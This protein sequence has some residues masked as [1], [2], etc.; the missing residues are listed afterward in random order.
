MLM[1]YRVTTRV[2]FNDPRL[3]HLKFDLTKDNFSVVDGHGSIIVL[4]PLPWFLSA[5][6][7]IFNIHWTMCPIFT[8]RGVS[9]KVPNV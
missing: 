4:C 1:L 9:I 3:L 6:C 8:G 5:Y 7:A 2:M